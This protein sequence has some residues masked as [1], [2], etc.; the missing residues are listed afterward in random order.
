M[1]VGCVSVDYVRISDAEV[2]PKPS[3]C[4]IEIFSTKVP[5]RDYVELGILEGK[6][7]ASSASL[8]DVLPEMK[9]KAC[10]VGG[11]AIILS[12]TQRS[13]TASGTMSA[14]GGGMVSNAT[15][16]RWQD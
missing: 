4:K 1:S 9:R 7:S 14:T 16:I 3:N 2:A 6:G 15:V 8:G 12:G 5:A 10:E 11:D 13:A